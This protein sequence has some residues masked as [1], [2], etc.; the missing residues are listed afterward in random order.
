[1]TIHCIITNLTWLPLSEE[2]CGCQKF[3]SANYP[4]LQGSMHAYS[5]GPTYFT[6]EMYTRTGLHLPI[7]RIHNFI[8][9]TQSAD[10]HGNCNYLQISNRRICIRNPHTSHHVPGTCVVVYVLSVSASWMTYSCL[11]TGTWATMAA[12]YV[13]VPTASS[14]KFASMVVCLA[15]WIEF[16]FLVLYKEQPS[17]FWSIMAHYSSSSATAGVRQHRQSRFECYFHFYGHHPI[18]CCTLLMCITPAT[19]KVVYLHHKP[20]NLM[21]C[22]FHY[23]LAAGDL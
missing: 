23:V 1:M 10:I 3:A 18:R 17:A 4:H 2:V 6:A 5:Y 16:F 20:P 12:E 19:S 7:I 14:S 8:S 22:E 13:T 15:Q 21:F 9:V 11:Q